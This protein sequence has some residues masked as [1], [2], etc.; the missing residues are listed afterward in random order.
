MR[1]QLKP[2]L[3]TLELDVFDLLGLGVRILLEF[4]GIRRFGSQ[5]Q[6]IIGCV[7]FEILRSKHIGVTNLTF[8][9]HVTSSIR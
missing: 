5:Q 6:Q 9:R 1:F 8:Q 3:M 2:R 7:V 4:H